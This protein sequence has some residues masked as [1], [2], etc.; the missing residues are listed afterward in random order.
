MDDYLSKPFRTE[1]LLEVIYRF[2][3]ERIESESSSREA[4]EIWRG[5]RIDWPVLLE[6]CR[7]DM[8]MA[9]DVLMIF[10]DRYEDWLS[11]VR[12][13]VEAGDALAVDEA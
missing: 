2:A 4:A 5:S 11:A 1:E 13:A 9:H 12:R 8:E 3:P 10:L 7:G 6:N